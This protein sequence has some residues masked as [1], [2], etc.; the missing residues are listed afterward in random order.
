MTEQ[1]VASAL[2]RPIQVH[3]EDVLVPVPKKHADLEQ[4]V[5]F[6]VRHAPQA[7]PWISRIPH[8]SRARTVA[9]RGRCSKKPVSPN[10]SPA[11]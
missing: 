5:E 3:G 6:E 4:H 8:A 11:A 9:E 10:V 1:P 7:L 2:R